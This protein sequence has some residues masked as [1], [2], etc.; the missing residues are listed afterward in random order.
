MH[1]Y[2]L[3]LYLCM[4]I[5]MNI[6][7]EAQ[8][9]QRYLVDLARLGQLGATWAPSASKSPENIAPADKSTH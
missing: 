5:Y 9:C 1:V 8:L 7:L 3:S 4:Y 2:V 6:L